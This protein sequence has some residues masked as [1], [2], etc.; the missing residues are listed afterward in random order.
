MYEVL[1]CIG[2]NVIG[3]MEISAYNDADA[4]MKAVKAI[5]I[6]TRKSYARTGK[7]NPTAANRKHRASN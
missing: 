4:Q 7:I 2:K 6:K 3:R 1:I 5:T